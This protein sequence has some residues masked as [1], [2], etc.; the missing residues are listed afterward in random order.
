MYVSAG[1]N[2][3]GGA[4]NRGRDSAFGG[5]MNRFLGPDESKMGPGKEKIK[6]FQKFFIGI[7]IPDFCGSWRVLGAGVKLF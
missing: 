5:K 6:N 7:K 4:P 3:V 1:S 2:R